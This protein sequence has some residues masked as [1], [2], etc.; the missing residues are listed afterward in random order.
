MNSYL[1]IHS[2]NTHTINVNYPLLCL[3]LTFLQVEG[4]G[5]AEGGRAGTA[6]GSAQRC[7]GRAGTAAGSAQWRP[8]R[9]LGDQ[10]GRQRWSWR[11]QAKLQLFRR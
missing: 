4:S 2:S 10:N 8:G 11:P 5:W 9:A 1:R 3:L 7:P 6:A